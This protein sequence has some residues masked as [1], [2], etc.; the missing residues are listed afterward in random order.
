MLINLQTKAGGE[1]IKILSSIEHFAFTNYN[2]Y[3]DSILIIHI[4]SNKK[5]LLSTKL[6]TDAF[7][8]LNSYLEE[9]L[10]NREVKIDLNEVIL[11]QFYEMKCN[12]NNLKKQKTPKP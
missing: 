11:N 5:I 2:N 9:S 1:D 7:E 6:K 10:L 3:L 4:P 12:E 8:I